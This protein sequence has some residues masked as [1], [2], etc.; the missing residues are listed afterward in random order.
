MNDNDNMDVGDSDPQPTCSAPRKTLPGNFSHIYTGIP[1][2]MFSKLVHQ[3]Y[4]I[5]KNLVM[6]AYC[7]FHDLNFCFVTGAP[8]IRK[9]HVLRDRRHVIT[10]DSEEKVTVWDILKVRIFI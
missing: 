7:Q 5:N 6:K 3:K 9:F 1:R 2:Y 10:K 4:T 8:S